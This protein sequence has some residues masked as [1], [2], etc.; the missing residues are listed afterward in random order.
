MSNSEL[1]NNIERSLYTFNFN[2]MI[3]L[4]FEKA[5]Y[6]DK[7]DGISKFSAHSKLSDQEKILFD[8][9]I[10]KYMLSFNI[11]KETSSEHL[12]NLFNSKRN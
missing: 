10:D 4:C 1:F 5:I 12:E 6:Q 7:A 2:N 8:N 3:D 11:V 9:C